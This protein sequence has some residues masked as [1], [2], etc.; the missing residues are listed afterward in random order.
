MR[1]TATPRVVA[2]T[3][4]RQFF[5]D[6]IGEAMARQALAARCETV[7][8]VADMLSQFCRT[9]RLYDRR[10]GGGEADRGRAPVLAFIYGQAAEATSSQERAQC[11]R[12]LGDVSLFLS[13]MFADS[14]NRKLVDVD[15]CIAMGEGAYAWLSDAARMAEADRRVF[16]EL[17]EK[18]ARVV[19]VLNAVGE[20]HRARG[21]ADVL[22]LYERWVRTGSPR[23]AS[24][25]RSQGIEVSAGA[26]S[27]SWH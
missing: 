23:A 14:F 15:Y 12:R 2:A 1:D 11:M 8:Y 9:D 7:D 5:R 6:A 26:A 16:A 24:R 4:V 3:D 13:G 18:F 20:D 25:L 10:R 19:D 22:R 17:A 21:P 27:R